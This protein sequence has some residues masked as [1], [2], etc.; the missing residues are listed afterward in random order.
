MSTPFKCAKRDDIQKLTKLV[1]DGAD[2]NSTTF[3]DEI[4]LHIAASRNAVKV[5]NFLLENHANINAKTEM[6]QETPIFLAVQ[7]NHMEAFNL[8]VEHGADINAE[9]FE[10][11]MDSGKREK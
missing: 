2:V 3:N 1:Q 5:I 7:E 8:L 10:G 11:E 9:N 4:A 6:T